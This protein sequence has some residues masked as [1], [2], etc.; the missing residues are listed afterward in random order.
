MP[1]N[2]YMGSPPPSGNGGGYQRNAPQTF[3]PTANKYSQ[4]GNYT[5]AYR[6][7]LDNLL[8]NPGSFSGTP[9]FQFALDQGMQGVQRSNSAG[10]NSGN[11]LAALAKY[12][13]DLA[14]Q[15]YGNQ[16]DR[17]GRLSG[18]Q[19]QFNLGTEQNRLTGENN[20]NN[21]NLGGQRNVNDANNNEKQFALGIGRNANDATRNANDFSLGQGRNANDA[22]RANQDFGLGIYRA[23]ND[24]TLGQGRNAN[25]Q[26][27]NWWNHDLGQGRNANEAAQNQNSWNNQQQRNGID[28]FRAGT[29]RGNNMSNDYFRGQD[30]QRAWGTFNR[31]GR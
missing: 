21:F 12:G 26:Q 30:N 7:Q 31:G 16:V 10:R 6:G 3:N 11:A 5:N 18:Q 4:P 15:D 27:N 23:G 25:E 13:T 19:D 8:T 29:D 14:Q 20:I 17:L 28:W 1:N 9:G 22:N 24:F 2:F